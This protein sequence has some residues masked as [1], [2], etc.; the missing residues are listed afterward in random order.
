MNYCVCFVFC[1]IFSPFTFSI[2][3]FS[4]CPKWLKAY[5]QLSRV[6]VG[7]FILK[8][9]LR[10]CLW[11]SVR[12]YSG[13][14]RRGEHHLPGVPGVQLQQQP[15]L[16]V[17]DPEPAARQLLHRGGARGPPPGTPPDLWIGLPAV[18]PG[19][20]TWGKITET[21]HVFTTDVLWCNLLWCGC[22]IVICYF[23]LDFDLI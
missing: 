2:E 10:H 14:P 7:I 16:W 20:V 22:T 6:A 23:R 15:E 21:E 5:N 4:W 12:R 3:S 1:A 11:R 8:Y 18:P 9:L 13:Q 17:A 19:W